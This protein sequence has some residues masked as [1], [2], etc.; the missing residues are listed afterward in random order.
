MSWRGVA[1]FVSSVL[2]AGILRLRRRRPGRTVLYYHGI[3]KDQI[4]SFERQMAH[5]AA[6]YQVVPAL[7]IRTAWAEGK[8]SLVALTFD[9]ALVSVQ[10]H[11]VPILKRHRLPATLPTGIHGTEGAR[12]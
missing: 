4:A 8:R 2:F 9:D 12:R 6:R 10:E 5:L 3:Q 7:R 11:V 1:A